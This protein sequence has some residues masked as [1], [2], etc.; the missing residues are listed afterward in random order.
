MSRG[1]NGRV[2]LVGISIF[3]AIAACSDRTAPMLEAPADASAATSGH[4]LIE[5]PV[6]EDSYATATLDARG[7][8]LRLDGHELSL[9]LGAVVAPTKFEL[10]APA[11]NYM[12]I[13][14]RANDQA[15]FDFWAPATV[16]FD[17]SRCT[18]SNIDKID[19]TV[20]KI[21]PETKALLRNMGGVDDKAARTVMFQTNDLSTFSIAR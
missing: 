5:C 1:R 21:H 17:Y 19:L 3:F 11:S 14:I 9:P 16:T 10:R 20:W 8:S 4:T 2:A 7:G 13:R 6:N 12:E 18:R 15:G